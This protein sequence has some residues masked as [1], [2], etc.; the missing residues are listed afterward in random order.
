MIFDA[1][2]VTE[3]CRVP[4]MSNGDNRAAHRARGGTSGLSHGF[5]LWV[6]THAGPS[7]SCLGEVIE[8]A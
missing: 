2:Y 6:G 7:S 4:H 3:H 1:L 5:A 8:T